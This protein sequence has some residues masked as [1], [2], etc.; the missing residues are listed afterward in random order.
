[1][2]IGL[3]LSLTSST[4]GEEHDYGVVVLGVDAVK[5]AHFVAEKSN[6]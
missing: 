6:K 5:R 4:A 2:G 1:V 3:S